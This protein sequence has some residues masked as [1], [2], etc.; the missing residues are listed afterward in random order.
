MG[1]SPG[2]IHIES[3]DYLWQEKR[4][5]D[6]PTSTASWLVW[7]YLPWA[8]GYLS[9]ASRGVTCCRQEPQAGG[10]KLMHGTEAGHQWAAPTGSRSGPTD[11]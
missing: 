6:S 9:K 2:D 11:Q 1:P 4:R 7:L 3:Q 10:E 8:P 5:I